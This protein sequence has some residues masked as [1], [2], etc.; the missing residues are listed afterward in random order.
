LECVG[1]LRR[2]VEL[3]DQVSWWI[4]LAKLLF[5]LLCVVLAILVAV[6][7]GTG[8]AAVLICRKLFTT[9]GD[10]VVNVRAEAAALR[11]RALE[12]RQDALADRR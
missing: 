10:S 11:I 9:S 1:E 8:G 3:G 6:L 12:R 2:I 7:C 5:V 4:V